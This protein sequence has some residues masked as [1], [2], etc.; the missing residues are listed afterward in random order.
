V[1]RLLNDFGTGGARRTTEETGSPS[2]LRRSSLV[3]P[4]SER[5]MEVLRLVATGRSNREIADQLVIAVS[6]VKSHT[7]TIFGKLGVKSRTQA[8]A[9]AVELGLL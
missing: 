1:T 7:N 2:I 9:R 4:L 8:V 5:E 6:T 3:E